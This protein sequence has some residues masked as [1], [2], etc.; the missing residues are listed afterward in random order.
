MSTS[1]TSRLLLDRY[2][3]GESKAAAELFDRYASRLRGL[4]RRRMSAGLQHRVDPEDVVQS[5]LR[6]FFVRAIPDEYVLQ[7]AGDLWRLLA[8]ITLSKLRRQVEVHTAAKRSVARETRLTDGL[9]DFA[10]LADREPQPGEELALLEELEQVMQA[11]SPAERHALQM[12][13]AGETFEDIARS[14][15]RSQRTVRRL[16]QASRNAVEQRLSTAQEPPS[17]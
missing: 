10:S 17:P 14:M 13:L 3:A 2:H 8:A 7:R 5:A 1:D 9:D 16:L 4:V 6:S 11:C 15:G 12:R